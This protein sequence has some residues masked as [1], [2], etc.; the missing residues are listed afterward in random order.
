MIMCCVVDSFISF[1]VSVLEQGKVL[2]GVGQDRQL[3]LLLDRGGTI[4]RNGSRKLEK[5]DMSV[6]PNLIELFRHLATVLVVR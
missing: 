4:K 5:L 2:Y 1:V 6:I 3:C